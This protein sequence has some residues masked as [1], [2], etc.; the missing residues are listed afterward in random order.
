MTKNRRL[1]ATLIALVFVVSIL[2]IWR[3][4]EDDTISRQHNDEHQHH[5][6]KTPRYKS[7]TSTGKL[8]SP[9]PELGQINKAHVKIGWLLFKDPQLSSNGQISCESCHDL[10]S[11]G[12]EPTKV[13]TGVEGQG[14]R[15][16]LTV[17]NAALNYRFFWDGR[18]NSL[19]DQIDGPIHSN[20]EMN[21]TWAFITQYVARS[22]LYSHLFAEQKLEVNEST[23]KAMLV[24]FMNAL[25]TP[26]APF[27]RYLRGDD[28][29]LTSHQI[30]GWRLFQQ[31]G[32]IRCH[33]G[34]NIGGG[35]VMK[36]GLYGKTYQ[37]EERSS[38][39][40]RHMHTNNMEDKYIFRVASL[41]NVAT[42]SP[43]FHDGQTEKLVD[44]IQ[45]MAQ[46][47]LGLSLGNDEIVAINAFLN[48]LS[49]DRPDIL[50]EL[51]NEPN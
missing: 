36:F 9:I 27:D 7:L 47:Q 4:S 18:A 46:S 35:M 29:A 21:S 3:L 10:A 49:A 42:T 14:I 24:E 2:S 1:L 25:V 50:K 19:N 22:P 30:E 6:I 40:G 48:S 41:R 34:T 12:A 13:S 39:T 33:R 26:N 11:N 5:D 20:I 51:E 28:T 32:C 45:I 17:F 16:S 23:I 31:Y 44:A 15:N 37:G 43:Y 8:I 38:D